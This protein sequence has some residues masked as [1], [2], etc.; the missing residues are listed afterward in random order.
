ML[1]K[2]LQ[3]YTSHIQEQKDFYSGLLGTDIIASGAEQFE[4]RIGNT[5]LIFKKSS[6]NCYYHFAINIPSYQIKE[7][8]QWISAKTKVLPFHGE[9]IVDF[10]NWNAEAL[11]FYDPSGNIVEFIA[12]KN[13]N[14][15]SDSKFDSG[16]FMHIS[17]IGLPVSDVR[18]TYEFLNRECGLAKFSGDYQRFCA[19]GEETGLFITI[20]YNQKDWIPNDDKAYPFPFEA[21]FVNQNRSFQMIFENAGIKIY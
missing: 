12:R 7:A 19:I 21:E 10:K 11:Y 3:L 14:I 5:A 2:T 9:E 1:F 20:D 13:L 15:P 6:E 8:H 17:E 4:V 16:S 18:S